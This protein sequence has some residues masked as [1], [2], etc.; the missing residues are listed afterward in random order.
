MDTI[1]CWKQKVWSVVADSYDK[2]NDDDDDVY[3]CS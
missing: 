3:I 1:W 2:N